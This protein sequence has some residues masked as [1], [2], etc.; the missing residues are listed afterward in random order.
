MRYRQEV[1]RYCIDKGI[2]AHQV[3]E[4]TCLKETREWYVDEAV[5]LEHLEKARQLQKRED[6]RIS[7]AADGT[8]TVERR[9][10]Y[11]HTRVV[12]TYT[13]IRT[14]QNTERNDD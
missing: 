2:Y 1:K 12:A 11:D 3:V 7:I 6:V 8:V 5:L 14:K 4:H 13:P 10:N 9:L